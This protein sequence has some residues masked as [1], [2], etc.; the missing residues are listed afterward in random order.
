MILQENNKKF[1]SSVGKTTDILLIKKL[2]NEPSSVIV[3][4]GFKFQTKFVTTKGLVTTI[5]M[6]IFQK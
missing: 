2:P 4:D 6:N 5:N 1:L 3:N